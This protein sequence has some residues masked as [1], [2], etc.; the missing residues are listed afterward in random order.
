MKSEFCLL[1][2]SEIIYFS[3][4]TL[5]ISFPETFSQWTQPFCK[6]VF[7]NEI[8]K[9]ITFVINN[10]NNF[11]NFNLLL[12]RLLFILSDGLSFLKSSLNLP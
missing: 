7:V 1:L 6:I 12:S 3:F 11:I 5:C 8:I 4:S 9:Q 2:S 10:I